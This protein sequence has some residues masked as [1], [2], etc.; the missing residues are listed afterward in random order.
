MKTGIIYCYFN[1]IEDKRYIGQ[2][3]NE[4]SRRSAFKTK[5]LYCTSLKS[6]GNLSKFDQARKDYGIDTFIYSVLCK[7]EDDDEKQL[8][9]RLNEL[10]IYYIK[11]FDS[12][13]NGY[14][15]TEGGLSGSL[16]EETKSK[17]S[18][19]LKGRPMSELTYQKLCLTGYIHTEESKKKIGD[20][21]KERYQDLT[22]HPMY[23]KH[24]T[25]ESKQKISESRKGKCK[26]SENGKSKAILCYT[27]SGEFIKEFDCQSDA[28]EWLGKDRRDNAMLSRCCNGK[29]KTAYGYV[30]KFKKQE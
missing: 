1:P 12:F 30:W 17:I 19:S 24:H 26:G 13:N 11:K 22:N 23:G 9:D 27:K 18:E 29:A 21:A 28:L 16:S 7:I 5:E 2:T 15:S 10:E 4:K 6:G 8:K 3:M 20:K 25:E 14:N